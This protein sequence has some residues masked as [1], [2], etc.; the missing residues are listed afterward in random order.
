MSIVSCSQSG[1]VS[2]YCLIAQ[3][4]YLD[5]AE[6]K[7]LSRETKTQILVHNETWA[8]KCSKLTRQ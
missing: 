6:V 4:I 8:Q 3:P 2:D 5:V 7:I 1:F